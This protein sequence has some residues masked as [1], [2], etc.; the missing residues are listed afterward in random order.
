MAKIPEPQETLISETERTIEEYWGKIRQALEADNSKLKEKAERES[1][2]II[3]R[4]KEEAD[5][6]L[7][8]AKQEARV[9]SERII[10]KAKEEVA[11]ARLESV[12]VITETKDKAN[13]IIAEVIERGTAQ[14]QSEFARAGSEAKDKISRLLAQVS[15]SAEQITIETEANIGAELERLAVIMAEA[16]TKLQP[17]SETPNIEFK[18]DLERPTEE[19][20]SPKERP[21]EKK[22]PSTL[23]VGDKKSPQLKAGDEAKLFKG[24]LKVEIVPRFG[25]EQLEGVPQ[26]LPRLPNLKVI[27][28]GG[29]AGATSWITTCEI[30]LSQSTP[31]LK[32]LKAVP[33]VETAAERYGYI[34]VKLK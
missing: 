5:K 34:V 32:I 1:S 21:S 12:R 20:P 7:A 27:S 16:Q 11:E 4:A 3:A 6:T 25:R 26:W 22:E 33:Q 23:P 18:A 29:Y 14:A 24:R 10:A 17:L 31:L 8:E 30:D 9:E 13:Q 2:Q 19:T 15:K 28:T